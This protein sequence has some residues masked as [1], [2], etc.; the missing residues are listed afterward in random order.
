[1][2]AGFCTDVLEEA[3]REGSKHEGKAKVLLSFKR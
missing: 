1:M 3:L 2:D